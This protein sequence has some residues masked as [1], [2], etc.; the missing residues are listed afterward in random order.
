MSTTSAS[1]PAGCTEQPA[2]Q[3]PGLTVTFMML[4][5]TFVV[6]LIVSNLVEMKTIS[7]RWFTITAGVIVALKK[8][9]DA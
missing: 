9:K 6:C 8:P 5:V 3:R 2:A 4:S 7:L 1:C